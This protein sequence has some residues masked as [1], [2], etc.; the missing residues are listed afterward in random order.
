MVKEC[1]F[2]FEAIII[3]SCDSSS[4]IKELTNDELPEL[5]SRRIQ[6]RVGVT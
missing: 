6:K 1:Q 2:F 4:I 3:F 5:S